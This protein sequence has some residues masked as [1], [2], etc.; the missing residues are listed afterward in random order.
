MFLR[1]LIYT[2][3]LCICKGCFLLGNTFKTL[4]SLDFTGYFK[5]LNK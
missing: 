1:Y 4:K 2:T 3:V 5:V